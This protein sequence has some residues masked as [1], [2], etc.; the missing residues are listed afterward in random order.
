MKLTVTEPER[1][2]Q[3]NSALDSSFSMPWHHVEII[4]LFTNCN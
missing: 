1:K 2:A 3:T 4:Q